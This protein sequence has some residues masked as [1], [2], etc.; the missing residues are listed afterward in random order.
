MGVCCSSQQEETPPVDSVTTQ[1]TV[2]L[3]LDTVLLD[4]NT[5][6]PDATV[7]GP[8]RQEHGQVVGSTDT[9]AHVVDESSSPAKRNRLNLRIDTSRAMLEPQQPT[10]K[11]D[12][13]A[14]TSSTVTPLPGA[15]FAFYE[16]DEVR[17]V[18]S[19][20]SICSF[21]G[22]DYGDDEDPEQEVKK[23]KW[24]NRF[25][26][27][28]GSAVRAARRRT[29][30]PMDCTPP[31]LDPESVTLREVL[32]DPLLSREF[33]LFVAMQLAEENITFVRDASQL[34]AI[35]EPAHTRRLTAFLMREYL[36]PT[37]PMS[38]NLSSSTRDAILREHERICNT[39]APVTQAS[40]QETRRIFDKAMEEVEKLLEQNF[41]RNFVRDFNE[42]TQAGCATPVTPSLG[43]MSMARQPDPEN[44]VRVVIV[45]GGVA[46][47]TVAKLLLADRARRFRVTLIDSK[48][49]FEFTPWISRSMVHPDKFAEK[50][51]VDHEDYL[52]VDKLNR[53]GY[54]PLADVL[55][56]DVRVVRQHYVVVGFRKVQYD[57]LVVASGA[58]YPS[59][60]KPQN[61]T[62]AYRAKQMRAENVEL[63][64]AESV[65]L[66]GGGLVACTLAAEI[67]VEHPDKQVTIVCSNRRLLARVPGAH[68]LLHRRL[69]KELGVEVQLA[70]RVTHFDARSD[71]FAC[72]DGRLI[73][74]D[75]TYWC[76]GPVPN[77][78]FML[79]EFAS[80][81]T[82]GGHCFVN[83][84]MQL[85]YVPEYSDGKQGVANGGRVFVAGDCA[86]VQHERT[87]QMAHETAALVAR[88]IVNLSQRQRAPSNVSPLSTP[89]STPRGTPRLSTRGLA[90]PRGLAETPTPA[91]EDIKLQQ[92]QEHALSLLV[93]LGGHEIIVRGDRVKEVQNTDQASKQFARML[94][95]LHSGE[96]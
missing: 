73:R 16:S 8:V 28:I 37:A 41:L 7:L 83:G 58:H 93:R 64:E 2:Q 50:V 18:M 60:L 26:R 36:L 33:E 80:C 42:R 24:R 72:S 20:G 81:V 84:A 43:S 90:T 51:C 10:S 39:Q 77:T 62:R 75:K 46:G 38:L 61:V 29:P 96:T 9:D 55:V 49:Y 32:R 71:A 74:A 40:L 27:S 11:G 54:L 25:L 14:C 86:E 21:G 92:L 66:V 6:S 88:N 67:K 89:R 53:S 23:M 69:V 59:T 95:F 45:G 13:S 4:C 12:S 57:Y 47:S 79:P 22:S 5:V 65:L 94:K 52:G 30:P 78:Q 3:P 76:A 17:S 19:G 63:A 56:G 82:R 91:Q 85:S 31:V 68:D 48:Q 44:K 70:R 1:E 34:Y 15:T 87:V 35:H